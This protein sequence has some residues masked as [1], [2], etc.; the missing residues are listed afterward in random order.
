MKLAG[1]SEWYSMWWRWYPFGVEKK[2]VPAPGSECTATGSPCRAADLHERG[3]A[4][5]ALD[6]ARRRGRVLGVDTDRAPVA[7]FAVRRTEP[8]RL[9]PIVGGGAD[10]AA[11]VDV[12]QQPPAQREQ[13]G[14]THPERVEMPGHER[15][16]GA[17]QALL[18]TSVLAVL[19]IWRHPG[20][21][22][23]EVAV[24]PRERQAAP[25]LCHVFAEF[26]GL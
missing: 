9:Q 20:R 12:G 8:G 1:N 2:S 23:E 25:R 3:V 22:G 6:L 11:E 10:R 24:G 19:A 7:A 26:V 21:R 18:G 4:G 16:V 14:R 15:R 17:G 13:D 5:P